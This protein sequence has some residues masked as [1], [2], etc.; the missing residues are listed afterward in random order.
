MH[1]HA[2]V[3]PRSQSLDMCSLRERSEGDL[4]RLNSSVRDCWLEAYWACVHL[5]TT[6]LCSYKHSSAVGSKQLLL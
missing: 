2:Q 6:L 4:H 5:H 3:V 1:S